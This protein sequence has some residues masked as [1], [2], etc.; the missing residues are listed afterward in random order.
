MSM[1]SRPNLASESNQYVSYPRDLIQGIASALN[2]LHDVEIEAAADIIEQGFCEH[3]K[4]LLLGNGGSCA[5]ASH[6]ATDLML[7]AHD[8]KLQGT[9][10]PLNEHAALLS[11]M[12]NDYG[13]AESGNAFIEATGS[14]GDI[15]IVLS[16]SGSSPNLV[17][18]AEAAVGMGMQTLLIG[19]ILAPASFPAACR[20]LVRSA[21][22]SVIE[23]AHTAVS[24]LLA[25]ILRR[26]F[27]LESPRCAQ[28]LLGGHVRENN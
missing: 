19:S 3:R 2:A 14:P 22:Y 25:D 17:N 5:T 27:G 13:F 7:I 18:A 12:A 20:I 16:C 8:G 6:L 4:I 11:A 28:A 10:I 15:L 26:R 24:H 21:H 1:R 23:T 9:V